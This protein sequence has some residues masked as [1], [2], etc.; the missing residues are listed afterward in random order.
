MEDLAKD[1]EEEVKVDATIPN[2]TQQQE[3]AA[4]QMFTAAE[5]AHKRKLQAMRDAATAKKKPA[6]P[7]RVRRGFTKPKKKSKPSRRTHVDIQ[8]VDLSDV[9]ESEGEDEV[10]DEDD[11]QPN[12]DAPLFHRGMA[13]LMS[14]SIAM[15]FEKMEKRHHRTI[16][17]NTADPN[18]MSGVPNAPNTGRLSLKGVGNPEMADMLRVAPAPNLVIEGDKTQLDV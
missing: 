14:D 1:L 3:D 4:R 8:D 18:S 13:K 16:P 9:L 11:A 17:V 2:K 5:T 12:V 10:V 6:V 15:A 7:L